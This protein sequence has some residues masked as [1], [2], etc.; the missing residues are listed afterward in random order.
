LRRTMGIASL[1]LAVGLVLVPFDPTRAQPAA[2]PNT[3]TAAERQAG[4]RLLF[5]GKTTTGWRGYREN[6]MRPDWKVV[7]GALTLVGG[8]VKHLGIV[9]V[10]Q[11][12]NFELL[13]DWRIAEGG[14]S[15]IMYR[16]SET[17]REP[18]LTGPEVQLLDNPRHPEVRR[19]PARGSGA[20]Y[21]LYA[22]TRDVSR[23]PGEWNTLRLLV[24]GSRVEHWLN[25]SKILEY[26]IGSPDWQQRLARS[27][28]RT[29]PGFARN[30]KG[31]LCLQEHNSS[32]QFRN[33]KLRSLGA[34]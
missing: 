30:A 31:H 20:C 34:G 23:P 17:A 3:L 25:G 12:D 10:E 24:N 19:N 7:D 2:A 14:N 27:K 1:L 28:W 15:G 5:D 6:A 4:W 21:D 11:F 33:I 16:V 22:P 26:E 29:E 18:H 13:I 8:G 9:T 32:A